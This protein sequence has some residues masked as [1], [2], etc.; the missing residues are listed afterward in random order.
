MPSHFLTFKEVM[1]RYPF[2]RIYSLASSLRQQ[3]HYL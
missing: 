3:P 1:I 2:S